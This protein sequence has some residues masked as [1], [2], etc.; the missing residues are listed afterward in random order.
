MAQ[1]AQGATP[2]AEDIRTA[3]DQQGY[4]RHSREQIRAHTR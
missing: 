1:P 4:Q 2:T 3:E